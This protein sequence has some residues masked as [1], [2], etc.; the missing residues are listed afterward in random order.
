[1]EKEGRNAHMRS[2]RTHRPWVRKNINTNTDRYHFIQLAP[3]LGFHSPLLLHRPTHPHT[4]FL[5]SFLFLSFLSFPI[6]G[7]FLFPFFSFISVFFECINQ[8]MGVIIIVL[9]FFS[10]SHFNPP[11]SSRILPSLPFLNCSLFTSL[12]KLIRIQIPRPTRPSA[13]Q[14]LYPTLFL[15]FFS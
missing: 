4:L 1:M 13:V 8:P 12:P 15:P 6:S 7:R 5:S 3:L 14:M 2:T 10:T 9:S 11:P